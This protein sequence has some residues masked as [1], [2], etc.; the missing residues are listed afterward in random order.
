M[1]KDT[2]SEIKEQIRTLEQKKAEQEKELAKTTEMIAAHQ[3]M[4]KH[5]ENKPSR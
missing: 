1:P 3:A 5:F 2:V 4:L